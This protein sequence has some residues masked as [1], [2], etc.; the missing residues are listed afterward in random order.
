MLYNLKQDSLY[1]NIY[2]CNYKCD[3]KFIYAL[4]SYVVDEN[5]LIYCFNVTEFKIESNMSNSIILEDVKLLFRGIYINN[6]NLVTGGNNKSEIGKFILKY[7]CIKDYNIITSSY[8]KIISD[9]KNQIKYDN[10][11]Y[12][13]NLFKDDKITIKGNIK[14]LKSSIVSRFGYN[15]EKNIINIKVL[16]IYTIHR[17]LI[18]GCNM[19]FKNIETFKKQYII[20]E[21]I[22]IEFI[23]DIYIIKYKFNTNVDNDGIIIPE[24]VDYTLLELITYH[25]NMEQ[26]IFSGYTRPII[27][28]S[29]FEIHIIISPQKNQ[30]I[31]KNELIKTMNIKIAKII[32]ELNNIFIQMQKDIK[33]LKK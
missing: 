11:L 25:L 23:D 32:T 28:R 26:K 33:T 6:D 30:K 27:S 16:P 5:H 7:T 17:M 13:F 22:T 15:H 18:A 14:L 1:K 12:L 3:D 31:K 24:N 29:N 10:K 21:N 9:F 20:N 19:Y 4:R 8:I 2:K